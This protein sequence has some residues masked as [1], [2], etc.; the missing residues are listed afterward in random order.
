MRVVCP[1][2]IAMVDALLWD[3]EE[4]YPGLVTTEAPSEPVAY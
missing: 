1:G 2:A 4:V 3:D